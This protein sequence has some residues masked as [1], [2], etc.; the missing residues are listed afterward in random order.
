MFIDMNDW[1]QCVMG[2]CCEGSRPIMEHQPIT[3]VLCTYLPTCVA[4]A[5]PSVAG[6]AR[7]VGWGRGLKTNEA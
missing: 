6:I 1:E 4:L 3:A 2:E 7:F 5:R